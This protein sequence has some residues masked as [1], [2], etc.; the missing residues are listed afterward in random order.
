MSFYTEACEVF[1]HVNQWIGQSDIH[2]SIAKQSVI[3]VPNEVGPVLRMIK[4]SNLGENIHQKFTY[5]FEG[6]EWLVDEENFAKLFMVLVK[7]YMEGKNFETPDMVQNPVTGNYFHRVALYP[8]HNIVLGFRVWVD[9]Y[10]EYVRLGWR[11]RV[12]KL[13]G[14]DEHTKVRVEAARRQ[15]IILEQVDE[16]YDMI[17]E[18]PEPPINTEELEVLYQYHEEILGNE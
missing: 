3:T 2:V 11:L 7:S 10:D 18:V 9:L 14:E 16:I 1:P 5:L 12:T 6:V 15:Q 17:A 8:Q 13:E 4:S